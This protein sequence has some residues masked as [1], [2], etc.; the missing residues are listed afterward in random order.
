M[1]DVTVKISKGQIN[2][3][4]K[5]D[6]SDKS[7]NCIVLEMPNGATTNFVSDRFNYRVYDY[8][9]DLIEKG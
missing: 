9:L 5:K 7:M 3:K 8:L 2:F 4:D 6:G 1:K